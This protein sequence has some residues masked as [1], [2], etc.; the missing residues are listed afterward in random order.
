MTPNVQD[1]NVGNLGDVVKH[2]A[3][4]ALAERLRARNAGLVRHVETHTFRLVA[5][6]PDVARWRDR[7]AAPAFAAYA[8]REAP[9]VDRGLYRCS[10]GLVADTLGAP[11]RLLLAE[12][13]APTRALLADA[14]AAEALPVDALVDDAAA[15]ATVPPGPPAPLLVHVDPFDHPRGYWPIVARLLE[16]WRAPA[17]DAAVLAFA[18][19]KAGPVTWP[20][21]P[22]GTVA[23]GR[24]DAAPYGL[25]AWATP[26]FA[27]DARDALRSLG[28]N[29]A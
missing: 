10:A 28:W 29:L 2:A 1:G 24:L 20:D 13:H 5:P 21:P 23:L 19:D 8:A 18:Y 3:L 9:W 27:D 17:H 15:L 4:V 25:A 26:A 16:T 12:A 14:L 22:P 7:T 6:L 11:V